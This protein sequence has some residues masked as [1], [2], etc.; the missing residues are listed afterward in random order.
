MATCHPYNLEP[1]HD[2]VGPEI[3]GLTALESSRGKADPT[4]DTDGRT[5]H[6]VVGE[7]L[8]HH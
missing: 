6:V 1:R 5:V 2:L 7:D 4:V 3:F 8:R